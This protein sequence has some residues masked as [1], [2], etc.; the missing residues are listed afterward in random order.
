MDELERIDNLGDAIRDLI[1]AD[2]MLDAITRAMSVDEKEEMYE[3]LCQVYDINYD[4][5]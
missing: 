2:E 1:G 5:E 4:I 3:F